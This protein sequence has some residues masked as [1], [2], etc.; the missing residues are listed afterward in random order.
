MGNQQATLWMNS[1]TIK[2]SVYIDAKPDSVFDALTSSADIVKFFPL[3]KVTSAWQVGGE[4]LL[5]GEVNGN[6]FRDYGLIQVLSR[7]H[8]FKYSYWSDNHETERTPVNHLTIDYRLYPQ[9]QGTKLEL[10]QSNLKSEE[11]FKVMNTVWDHLLSSL[12]NYVENQT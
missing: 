2:K 11:M 6:A 3:K 5:D 8:Q 7:P 9:Q 12:A 4:I 1:F 10:E